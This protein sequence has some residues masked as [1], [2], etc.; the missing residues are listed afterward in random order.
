MYFIRYQNVLIEATSYLNMIRPFV[1]GV[2]N[3]VLGFVHFSLYF[4]LES[5]S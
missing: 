2:K 4:G 3:D 1:F 5:V